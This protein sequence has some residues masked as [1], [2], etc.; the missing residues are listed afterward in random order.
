MLI[1][2][3][4]HIIVFLGVATLAAI[5]V[6]LVFF[7]LKKLVEI[8]KKKLTIT[9]G[10]TVAIIAV[11]RVAKE[12]IDEAKKTGNIKNLAALEEMARSD[13]VAIAVQDRN[14]NIS[15]DDIEIYQAEQVDQAIYNQ[16]D[17]DCVLL[18]SA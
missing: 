13:G 1:A 14:G 9:V 17:E 16:M 5:T 10:G 7:A 15:K 3:L 6:K 4:A 8:L 18:V 11:K 2:I 12:A